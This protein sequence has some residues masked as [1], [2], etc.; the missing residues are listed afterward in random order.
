[1][2]R[3]VFNLEFPSWC[4]EFVIF[5]Y[6]FFRVSDYKYRLLELSHLTSF[7]HEF[8]VKQNSGV[9]SVTAYVEVPDLEKPSVLAWSDNASALYDILLLLSIFTGR[10]VFLKPEEETGLSFADPRQYYGGGILRASIPY[11]AKIG[12]SGEEYDEGF[13]LVVNKIYDRIR[14][15][16][17]IKTYSKGNLLLLARS[18]FLPQRIESSFIASWIIWEHIFTILNEPWLSENQN[19][20]ISAIEKISF[21][22]VHFGLMDTVQ[23]EKK[24]RL[25]IFSG[26]RNNLIHKRA[27]IDEDTVDNTRLFL[28]LT[29]MMIAKILGLV[30][31]NVLN[32]NEHFEAFLNDSGR[33]GS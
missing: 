15:P 3:E 18:S 10:N 32:T 21:L 28:D 1:M 27:F 29:G 22:L 26:I 24:E 14:S 30:P 23:K 9:N 16:N 11:S 2:K 7:Q 17:W 8:A 6:R 20:R 25:K 33:I 4:D 13:E 31:S 12:R 5:G 19:R